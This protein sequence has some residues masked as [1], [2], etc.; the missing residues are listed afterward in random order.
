MKKRF[1]FVLALVL[2][3]TSLWS[4]SAQAKNISDFTDVKPGA[5]YYNAVHYA[6]SNELFCGTSATTFSPNTPMTRGMFITVLGRLH[7]VEKSYGGERQ[8][9]FD[10]VKKSDYFYP[11][12]VWANESGI[13][14]GTG[15]GFNPNGNIT[16]EQMAVML[17]NYFVKLNTFSLMDK[18]SGF[19]TFSDCD[20]VSSFARAA[21]DWAVRYGILSG[22]GQK[23]LEPQGQATRAQVAQIFLSFSRL[24]NYA[25]PDDTPA[26]TATPVPT[27][28]PS[29]PPSPTPASTPTAEPAPTPPPWYN[30]NPTYEIPTGK[31]E[32]DAHGGYFDYDLA[33]EVT[34]QINE[35]RVSLGMNALRFHP[36]VR[37][38]AD[39]RAMESEVLF[40][41]T[42]PDGS[43]CLTVGEGLHTENIY[44]GLG[45]PVEY[46][47]DSKAMAK[48][49]VDNWYNSVGHRQNMLH[50]SMDVATV[51]C[52]VVDRNVYAAHLFSKH[53]LY[54]F[55][56][57]VYDIY[58]WPRS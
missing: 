38:W 11:Y 28:A 26:P 16:R 35:L 40:E 5:W 56:Y 36:L 12:A 25:V 49:I 45:Y 34:R 58:G 3:I 31:S 32:V 55:D 15:Y 46:I 1:S 21:M 18:D 22:T 24:K 30:Y 37:D 8:S 43:V 19:H 39:I 7:G 6:V 51:S 29:S 44:K 4:P 33:N 13:T 50:T 9:S 48:Q 57:D 17:Y 47:C 10:D 53:P 23:K 52:Y 20:R 2:L 54:F 42:R 41:H 14:S 27:L